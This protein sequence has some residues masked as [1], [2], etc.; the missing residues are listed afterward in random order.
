MLDYCTFIEI[1]FNW[2]YIKYE[3]GLSYSEQH[4][5]GFININ[6]NLQQKNV[7][8]NVYNGGCVHPNGQIWQRLIDVHE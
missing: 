1:S 8:K 4:Y 6:T 7:I 2:F 3:P 5:I